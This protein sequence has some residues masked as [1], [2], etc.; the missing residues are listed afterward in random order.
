MGERTVKVPELRQGP[1]GAQRCEYYVWQNLESDVVNLDGWRSRLAEQMGK[2]DRSR[3]Q[4]FVEGLDRFI[5]QV[6][7][8]SQVLVRLQFR[9][10]R[11]VDLRPLV[12]VDFEE[13]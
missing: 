8:D 5:A 11:D 4:E 13:W 1:V 6:Q 9:E 10:Y 2:A 3:L 12:V 7:V